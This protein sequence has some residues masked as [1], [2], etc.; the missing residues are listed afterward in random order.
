MAREHPAT[1]PPLLAHIHISRTGGSTLNHIMR[2]SYGTRHCPVEP[3]DTRW[4]EVAFGADDLKRLRR[5]YPRLRSIAGH[6]V[7]GYGDLD[8]DEP[9]SY[10]AWMRDPLKACASRFQH[11]VVFQG[12]PFDDF[13]SWIE[14]DWTRNRH[15][16]AISGGNSAREAMRLIEEKRIFIGLTERYDESLLMLKTMVAPDLDISYEPVNVAADR[17]VSERLLGDPGTRAMIAES[18]AADLELYDYVKS[19]LHPAYRQTYGGELVSDL[20]RYRS[21]RRDSFNRFNLQTSRLKAY[22]LYRPALYL[23]RKTLGRRPQT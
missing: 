1:D 4:G 16:K 17:S 2:S 10:V 3:W 12:K 14:R 9:V 8:R 20:E 18:Q 23:H 19:E 22:G 21:S 5:L 6:R 15:T 13:E 11:R 7:F